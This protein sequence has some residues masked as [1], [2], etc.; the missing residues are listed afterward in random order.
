ML[1]VLIRVL[2]V[3][4]RLSSRLA[5]LVVLMSPFSL[6]DVAFFRC[7]L[8]FFA[9]SLHLSLLQRLPLQTAPDRRLRRWKVVF[10]AP[11]CG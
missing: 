7:L 3:L 5:V 6:C 2:T 8:T 9:L 11:I 10:V 1:K 4:V